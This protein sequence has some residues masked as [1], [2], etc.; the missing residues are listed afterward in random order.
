MNQ[1]FKLSK[2]K[3]IVGLGNVGLEYYKTRHNAGFLFLNTLVDSS[4][5]NNERKFKAEIYKSTNMILAKPTTMMNE[6]GFSVQSIINFYK[7]KSEEIFLIYDDLDIDLGKYKIQFNKSPKGHNGVLSVE[8]KIGTTHFWRLRIGVD[9]RSKELRK[10]FSGKD[11]VLSRFSEDEMVTLNSTF[12]TIVQ[13][14]EKT[15]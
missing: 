2:I 5:F 15:L 14:L 13:E 12:D 6:S 10:K 8:N 1:D 9:G 11:Y 3:L 7:I 4:K